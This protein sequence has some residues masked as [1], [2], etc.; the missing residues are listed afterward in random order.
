MQ[1]ARVQFAAY[2]AAFKDEDA[3]CFT[4]IGTD[5]FLALHVAHS[6]DRKRWTKRSPLPGLSMVESGPHRA[7]AATF[8][9]CGVPRLHRD[10]EVVNRER[11]SRLRITHNPPVGNHLLIGIW[12]FA[13]PLVL[14]AA[15]VKENCFSLSFI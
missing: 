5:T 12:L 14:D 13:R 7:L 6:C 11:W 3:V 15:Q 10:G 1:F 4:H 2:R 8:L 9:A